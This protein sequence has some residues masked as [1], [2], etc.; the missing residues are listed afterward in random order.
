LEFLEKKEEGQAPKSCEAS[1]NDKGRINMKKYR[2][3][4]FEDRV[5][6]EVWHWERKSLKFMAYRLGVSPST[7]SRELQRGKT[8][9][10]AIGYRADLG[11]RRKIERGA[12]K[13]ARPKIVGKTKN[14]IIE[15]I[16]RDWSPEQISGRLKLEEK[17][18]ISHETIYTFIKA[19]R[20]SGGDLFLHL[21]H[22]KR[23]R[24]KRFSIP[25]IRADI[26]NRK[27]IQTRP[28]V[29]NRRERIGD[30]ERDLMFGD[31]RSAAL[32]TIVER[33]TLLTIIKIVGSKSPKVIAIKTIEALK[34]S[35]VKCKSITNDN[36][37]EF[38]E[39][40]QESE[41]LGVPIYF[42]NPYSSWEKGT[43]EN[44]NGLIRQY[45]TRKS[46]MKG[47]TDED[48][49]NIERKLNT[50]PRKKLGFQTP[51]EA[52]AQMAI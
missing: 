22:G 29:I 13:G 27:H 48:T 45:F 36:G 30:W 3:L 1:N 11:E 2:H 15:L 28:E 49:K 37:F 10:L 23:R 33:K 9:W 47:L 41:A 5:Y 8:G 44:I 26:L 50:R 14:L 16:R 21:R 42:T 46:S 25:R 39:H 12:K 52:C 4:T 38:R 35:K 19:D 7:I 20:K 17:L 18:L 24:K 31:S 43:C 34:N 40:Q 32:L 51:L 6:I